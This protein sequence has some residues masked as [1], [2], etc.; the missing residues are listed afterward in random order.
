M[1]LDVAI[2]TDSPSPRTDESTSKQKR[3]IR[4]VGEVKLL[5]LDDHKKGHSGNILGQTI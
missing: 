3:K 2:R 5:M 4:K 1:D